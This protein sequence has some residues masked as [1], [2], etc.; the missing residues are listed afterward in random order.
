MTGSWEGNSSAT[1]ASPSSAAESLAR[2]VPS[3]PRFL[4]SSLICGSPGLLRLNI[5]LV[6]THGQERESSSFSLPVPGA[7]PPSR[8]KAEKKKNKISLEI[9]QVFFVF[10]F[11]SPL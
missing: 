11:F 8:T 10:W 7:L 9:S 3:P 1:L 4:I 6:T 2:N 5:A